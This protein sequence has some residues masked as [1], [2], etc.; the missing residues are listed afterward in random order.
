MDQLL[1][2]LFCLRCSYAT[3]RYKD[4]NAPNRG[5]SKTRARYPHN[6]SEPRRHMTYKDTDG[7]ENGRIKHG[8]EQKY[9]ETRFP[10]LTQTFM[11]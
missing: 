1:D 6:T 5:P 2:L 8:V 7:L 11:S 10:H 4:V 9:D 3:L